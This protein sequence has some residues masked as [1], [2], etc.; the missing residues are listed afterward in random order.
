M[1]CL[2]CGR[3]TVANKI[4]CEDCLSGMD[5]YPVKPG[6]AI[7]LP[8]RTTKV[9]PKKPVKRTPTP[10]EQLADLKRARFWLTV[11]VVLLSATLCLALVFPRPTS[12]AM[13]EATEAT[14]ETAAESTAEAAT[15]PIISHITIRPNQ[16]EGAS[17]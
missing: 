5:R 15:G 10:E 6:T 8:Q 16:T 11:A 2:K 9:A 7:Q 17:N 1:Y 14:T 12:S 13:P 4:F 3:D